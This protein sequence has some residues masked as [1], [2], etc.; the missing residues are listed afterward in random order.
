LTKSYMDIN[1]KVK[2]SSQADIFEIFIFR[3]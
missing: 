3:A 2:Q 1:P